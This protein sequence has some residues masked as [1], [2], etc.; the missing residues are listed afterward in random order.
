MGWGVGPHRSEGIRI[1]DPCIANGTVGMS[2]RS[3][4][5]LVEGGLRFVFST[6]GLTYD[7]VFCL[8]MLQKIRVLTE[9]SVDST[10]NNRVLD[11]ERQCL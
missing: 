5:V 6:A 7:D 4:P 11:P 8:Y 9:S 3:A 2:I 10:R 1:C